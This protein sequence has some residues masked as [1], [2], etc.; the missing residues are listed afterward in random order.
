MKLFPLLA[1]TTPAAVFVLAGCGSAPDLS[2]GVQAGDTPEMVQ[3]AMG[4]P[5]VKRDEPTA[6]GHQ[7][8]WIYTNYHP[9]ARQRTGWSEVLVAGTHDKN[10]QVVQEPVT[11]DVYRAQAKD[12]FRVVFTAGRVSS[13]EHVKQ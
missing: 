1:V 12:D 11:H 4:K 2:A 3:R 5:D 9:Q 6:G 10:D 8:V 13:V 7:S